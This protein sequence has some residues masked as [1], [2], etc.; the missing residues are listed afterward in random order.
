MSLNTDTMDVAKQPNW[1]VRRAMS[2]FVFTLA[3]AFAALTY[4]TTSANAQSGNTR[5]VRIGLDKSIVLRLPA[6][7]HDVLIG[8]PEVVDAVVRTRKTAYLFARKVGQTNAFFFDASGRQILSLD[9]EV[10][11]DT[12]GL[13]K[14]LQRSIPGNQITVDT[15]GEN[16]VLGGVAANG[17]QAK[18]A[19]DLAVRYTGSDKKV[20]TMIK[21]TGKEQVMLRVRIA[22]VQRDVVKQFGIDT[23]VAFTAGS[24]FAANVF[25]P[26]AFAPIL[27]NRV[28]ARF[29]EGGDGV[30]AI[31]RA[32]ENDGLLRT[33]AE[34]TLTAVSGESAK[35]LAGGEFPVP[36]GADNNQITVEFKPFGVG[37][38]FTPVVLSAGRISMRIT[39]EVSELT[40]EN[41]IGVNTGA[42]QINIPG[43]RVRR[44]ET[45]V[46]LPS[47]GSMVMAGLIKEETKQTLAGVPGVKNLPVI[48]ALF[49]SR[50]FETNQTEMVAIVT[51][52]VVDAVNDKQLATPLDRLNFATDRQT[53][54]FGR[55]NKIYGVAGDRPKGTY[56]GNV[57]FI[58]E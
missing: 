19:F 4:M 31:V 39:T 44:A 21:I 14:L 6:E 50:D 17:A 51:P 57:G 35:F 38:G 36:V 34:P 32:L 24:N 16:V 1:P 41:S 11:H 33:L 43:L 47:G 29:V 3:V 18:T 53:I 52:F 15:V 56:H 37:L 46:E 7:A 28:S 5:F 48:G 40:T 8:N 9:I 55:L 58:V 13:T 27:G 2:A 23:E 20:M 22:E 12:K 45:T 54:L 25:N 26:I 49:R 10:S 42:G 30:S